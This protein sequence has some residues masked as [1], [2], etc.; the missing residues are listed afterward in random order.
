MPS[1]APRPVRRKG[2]PRTV[3]AVL[4]PVLALAAGLAAAA[5]FPPDLIRAEHPDEALFR[6]L[7]LDDA[8]GSGRSPELQALLRSPAVPPDAVHA[9]LARRSPPAEAVSHWQA[10]RAASPTSPYREE[11]L[12]ALLDLKVAAGELEQAAELAGELAAA[13]GD[14]EVQ[15]RA[16]ARLLEVLQKLGRDAEARALAETLWV[17]FAAFPESAAGEAYLSAG[18]GEPLRTVAVERLLGRGRELLRRGRREAAVATLEELRGRLPDG[19][20]LAPEVDLNLGK[21]LYYL[22]RYPEA[23][24][25]LARVAAHP[26]QGEEARFLRARCLFGLNRGDEGAADLVALADAVPDGAA[27]PTYLYQAYRVFRGRELV[28]EADGARGRLLDRYGDSPEARELRWEDGWADW[29]AGRL[30][31]AAAAFRESA[32]SAREWSAAR[33][34]YWQGKVLRAQERPVPARQVWRQLVA[35]YPLGYYARLA[36]RALG[37]ETP[38]FPAA[39]PRGGARDLPVYGPGEGDPGSDP[40]LQ[41]VFAYLRLAQP[42]AAQVLLRARGGT[43]SEWGRL[44]YWAEDFRGAV[45]AAGRSWLDWPA[46]PAPAPLDREGLAFPVAFP[47][48]AGRAAEQAGIHPHLLLAVAH[49]ESHFDPKAYSAWEARGVMQFIPTT[50]AAVAERA[51]RAEFQ[52]EDLF[53]PEVALELGARHLREL[54]DRFDGDVLAAVA[55]YNA[56]AGAVTRWRESFGDLP[57]DAWVESI[58]YRETRRY[59]KKVATALDAYGRLDPPGLVGKQAP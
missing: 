24:A 7:V 59:V 53:E 35:D 30:E 39:D 6:R 14:E 18:G 58:P 50:G 48:S 37:G 51:G 36:E 46:G 42:E 25:A 8:P 19:S 27:A 11:A 16:R 13:S 17:E 15:A 43:G 49:T 56:G 10:V 9:A 1:V 5:E 2:A 4:V 29:R 32:G 52:P 23:S 12:A 28:A 3:L 34:V 41:R 45:R 54:L 21:A 38:A 33:A 20:E 55:A 44:C 31:A 40:G 22:R 26:V 47:A 57:D